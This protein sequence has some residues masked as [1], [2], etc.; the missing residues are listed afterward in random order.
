MEELT[1]SEIIEKYNIS[2]DDFIEH[3][4][5]YDIL[6]KV[7]TRDIVNCLDINHTLDVIGVENIINCVDNDELLYEIG[8]YKCKRYF[9]LFEQED[10]DNFNVEHHEIF[11]LFNEIHGALLNDFKNNNSE[12]LKYT[13][14]WFGVELDRYYKKI[15]GKE[16]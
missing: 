7:S 14:N 1:K 12:S 15:R 13:L 16:Y 6:D 3:Y 8:E 4:S 11:D 9:N 5:L 2:I 10:F